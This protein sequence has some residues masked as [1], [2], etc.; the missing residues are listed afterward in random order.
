MLSYKIHNDKDSMFNTPPVFPVYAC[1]LS[2]E[3][4]KS[5]GGIKEIEKRNRLKAKKL[6]DEIDK[7]ELFEGFAAVEDRSIMNVT[8]NL[9]D[10]SNKDIFD[11]IVLKK[12]ISGINGHRSV[13]GYRASIYN[14]LS[15]ESVET[16]VDA[17]KQFE[18]N[19]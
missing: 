17:M 1:K 7:N 2:M 4:L 11:E 19:I 3:W 12:N 16:L 10:Q 15:L 8:F 13:G 6:Y 5:I 18:K 14:A 9:T